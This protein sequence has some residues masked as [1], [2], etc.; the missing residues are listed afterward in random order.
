MFY[1]SEF[2]L[3]ICQMLPVLMQACSEV[4]ANDKVGRFWDTVYICFEQRYHPSY[5]EKVL[6]FRRISQ[7]V[8]AVAGGVRTPGPPRPVPRL[9]VCACV[10]ACVR[11]C[12][13]VSE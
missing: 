9:C 7:V 4:T 11:E 3:F 12:V 1:S 2:L 6:G 10:R 13:S 8:L 5:H